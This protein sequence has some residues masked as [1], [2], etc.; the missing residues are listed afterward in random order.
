MVLMCGSKLTWFQTGDRI[1]LTSV[2]ASKLNW[3]L[4]G[5][6]KLTV[7]LLPSHQTIFCTQR[8]RYTQC[9]CWF[10]PERYKLCGHRLCCREEPKQR[11][12]SRQSKWNASVT[13]Y[14]NAT[15]QARPEKY[16]KRN[17]KV[18]K[19]DQSS[20]ECDAI[21][22][23]RLQEEQHTSW[24]ARA[25]INLLWVWWSTDLVLVWVV[26]ETDSFFDA[27]GISLGFSVSI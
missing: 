23:E 11:R 15:K 5:G 13:C 8:H 2:V 6:S 16:G 18:K 12:R 26:V 4:C 3:F 24:R 25:E 14:K 21:R 7:C 1:G 20:E 27:G 22:S 10:I 17:G 19:E 9:P